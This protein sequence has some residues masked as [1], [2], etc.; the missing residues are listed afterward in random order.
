MPFSH[1]YILKTVSAEKTDKKNSC[2]NGKTICTAVFSKRNGALLSAGQAALVWALAGEHFVVEILLPV[3]I[4]DAVLQ[5]AHSLAQLVLLPRQQLFAL[6]DRCLPL[7]AE[8]EVLLHLLNA[9][10]AFFSGRSGF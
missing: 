2:V 7:Q 9:H 8:P 4:G 10:V 1:G 5:V 6:G 3:D